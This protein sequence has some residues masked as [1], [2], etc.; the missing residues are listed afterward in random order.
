LG[1]MEWIMAG[2]RGLL[3]VRLMRA[4][5]G[6]LYDPGF[7]FEFGR[8]CILRQTPDDTAVI[9]SSGRGVHEALA[10]ADDCASHGLNVGVVDLP[11]IDEELLLDLY[12]SGK[13]LYFA[14]QNNGYI[15]R[16]FQKILFQRRNSIATNRLTAVNTLGPDGKPHFIHSG[17]YPQLLAAFGLSPQQLSETLRRKVNE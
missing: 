9:I 7:K 3:Y 12:D 13:R 11:S 8:G 6:V 2:N 5:S 10:A 16:N 4:S 14:E 17:T 1:I 15:W